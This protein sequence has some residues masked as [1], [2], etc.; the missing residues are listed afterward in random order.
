MRLT[1]YLDGEE[2]RRWR[3]RSWAGPGANPGRAAVR[4]ARAVLEVA[5]GK[6][7]ERRET[8]ARF[9]RVERWAEDSG[10]A[11]LMGRELPPDGVLAADQRISWWAGELR[12][13][14]LE[15]GMDE[16]A[17]PRLPGTWSSVRTPV[18]APPRSRRPQEPRAPRAPRATMALPGRVPPR[19]RVRPEVRRVGSPAG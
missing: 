18:P 8:A 9:A 11:A 13:A 10:N 19:A 12:A 14:G 5:P 16:L 6:A 17:R 1:Q 2:P 4:A 7:R 15:G 3:R